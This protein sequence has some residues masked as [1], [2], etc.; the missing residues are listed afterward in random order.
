MRDRPRPLQ[1]A[2][3]N[4]PTPGLLH[5][6]RRHHVAPSLERRPARVA[7][8]PAARRVPECRLQAGGV[9]RR[10]LLGARAA[11]LARAPWITGSARRGP[12]VSGVGGRAREGSAVPP[13]MILAPPA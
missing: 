3:R 4:P 5:G 10:R 11:T 1:L 13:P 2:L 8:L 7:R 12:G 6:L 9:A